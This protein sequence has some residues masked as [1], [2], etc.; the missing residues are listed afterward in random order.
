MLPFLLVAV[1]AAAV[2]AVCSYVVLRLSR[3]YRLAP[4]VR[5]RDVHKQP[6][7]R[8]GGV[9]M[10]IGILVALIFAGTLGPFAGVF[11]GRTQLWVLLGACAL[12]A[13][14]GVLDDLLDLDW[15]VKLGAQLAAAGILAWN[16]AQIISL[17][18][19]DTLIVGSPTLNFMLT[20]FLITLVMNAVNF[21]DGLDGLVAGVA[22]ISNVAFFIYTQLLTAQV[23][24]DPSITLA[25]LIAAV[26]VGIS[27]GFL[28]FNWHRARM[29][30]GDTGALL[31]GLLMA[32][33]TVS[34]TGQL[35]PAQLDQKLVLASYIPII[36][37]MAVLAVPLA[38]FTL[39]VCRRLLAGKSPFE[40]DRSH[41]HHRLLDMGHSPLQ[42]V[43]IFYLWTAM[44]S[45]A[46][47]L[48]FV[49]QSFFWPGLVVIAGGVI[50]VVV[51]FMPLGRVRNWL[52]RRGLLRLTDASNDAPADERILSD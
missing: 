47:L 35:N 25:A 3:R 16:G 44:V 41:L 2:T 51:T 21:V 36:L 30:M 32:T 39:A 46:C 10:F 12:I 5:E 17:P 24:A 40:A 33:S 42:A 11:G 45:L 27:V 31:I 52:T 26:V 19:G 14:V 18:F 4:E 34:V 20:V 48:V 13:F 22:I 7:P 28:P 6:T 8:L 38:D 1:V 50:C 9:A 15:M 23:G 37:P 49:T 29:F 43:M